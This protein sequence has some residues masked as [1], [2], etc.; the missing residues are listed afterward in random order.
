MCEKDTR[1]RFVISNGMLGERI[2]FFAALTSSVPRP[3]PN[4][5]GTIRTVPGA[6]SGCVM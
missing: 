6:A 5:P 2:T 4:S 3:V 1:D